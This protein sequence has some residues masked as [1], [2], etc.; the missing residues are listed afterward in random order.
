M[1]FNDGCPLKVQTGFEVRDGEYQWLLSGGCMSNV[2][3]IC[4]SLSEMC[5]DPLC[6]SKW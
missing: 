6:Y 5:D 3:E 1:L 2:W 4:F